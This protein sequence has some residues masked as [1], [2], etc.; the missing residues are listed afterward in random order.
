M[1]ALTFSA[2]KVNLSYSYDTLTIY[3]KFESYTQGERALG[4]L[5]GLCHQLDYV[6][7]PTKLEITKNLITHDKCMR[8]ITRKVGNVRSVLR[9]DDDH[10]MYHHDGFK[11]EDL[12]RHLNFKS[13]LT[14]DQL[15]EILN[16]LVAQNLLTSHEKI[17]FLKALKERYQLAREKLDGVVES[18]MQAVQVTTINELIPFDTLTSQADMKA[19]IHFLSTI[20]DN[21]ILVDLHC[22]LLSEKFDYLRNNPAG[23]ASCWQGT[24]AKEVVIKTSQGWAMIEKSIELRMARNIEITCK[25]TTTLAE[26]RAEQF[27]GHK[28]FGVRH[29]LELDV[30]GIEERL[31]PSVKAF[32]EADTD[33]LGQQYSALFI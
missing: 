19:I 23:E 30:N 13:M 32:R 2:D 14:S 11:M 24:D 6:K 10:G 4:Y 27:L 16:I 12:H 31:S 18:I 9:D 33:T 21:E 25:F 15:S 29:F 20:E 26:K 3:P 28:F 22:Y 8:V 7:V 1:P 17:A 5:L